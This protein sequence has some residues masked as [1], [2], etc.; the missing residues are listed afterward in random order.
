MLVDMNHTEILQNINVLIAIPL[1]KS[2]SFIAVA[3]EI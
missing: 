3:S 1:R 2:G